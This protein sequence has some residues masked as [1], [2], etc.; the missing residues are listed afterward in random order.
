MR[1]GV[2]VILLRE[3]E[4]IVWRVFVVVLFGVDVVLRLL[5]KIFEVFFVDLWCG[6]CLFLFFL[7][8]R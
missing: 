1:K 6:C 3:F 7:M 4:I 5:W 2:F 8:S